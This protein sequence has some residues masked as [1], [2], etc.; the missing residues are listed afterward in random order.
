[1][2]NFNGNLTSAFHPNTRHSVTTWL[3]SHQWRWFFG[4]EKKKM[5]VH[6]TM[7]AIATGKPL[8]DIKFPNPSQGERERERAQ[9]EKVRVATSDCKSTGWRWSG[10]RL[11]FSYTKHF[12]SSGIQQKWKIDF[13]GSYFSLFFKKG[14]F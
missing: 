14:C 7:D 11:M 4:H 6:Q 8:L 12:F 3:S 10:Y 9:M 2:R 13:S 5:F 1:M